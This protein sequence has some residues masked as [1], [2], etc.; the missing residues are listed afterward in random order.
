[1]NKLQQFFNVGKRE[2]ILGASLIMASGVTMA[3]DGDYDVSK[4]LLYAAGGIAGATLVGAAM[5]G[6]VS[7][8]GVGKK[9]QRAGT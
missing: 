1:M 7:L 2:A 4:A 9:L 3:A 6:L 8:I 5:F